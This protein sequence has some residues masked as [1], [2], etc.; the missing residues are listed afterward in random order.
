MPRWHSPIRWDI[1]RKWKKF[2]I[3]AGLYDATI[4]AKLFFIFRDLY[5]IKN[6]LSFKEICLILHP[7]K[8]EIDKETGEEQPN[9][10]GYGL[11]RQEIKN[12]RK[13]KFFSKSLVL[14]CMTDEKTGAQIYFNIGTLTLFRIVEK[15]L[16]KII[17][18]IEENRDYAIEALKIP[19]GRRKKLSKNTA[20]EIRRQIIAKI[21]KQMERKRKMEMEQA[22]QEMIQQH[23]Q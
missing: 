9:I 12:L 14:Y 8:V 6:G 21:A 3:D 7:D 4:D 11:T 22:A 1:I 18:G 20:D 19:L 17:K 15:R 10:S 23:V 2:L 5:E 13:N 16:N